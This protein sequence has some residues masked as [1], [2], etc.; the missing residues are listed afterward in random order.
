MEQLSPQS[1]LEYLCH[2]QK[3]HHA[4][5]QSFPLAPTQSH[6]PALVNHESAFC[7]LDLLISEFSHKWNH[8][9]HSLVW[10]GSFTWQ[11]FTRHSPCRS[12]H[13]DVF[14]FYNWVILHCID[15]PNCVYPLISWLMFWTVS[16]FGTLAVTN[17][18]AINIQ[19]QNFCIAIC[20]IFLSY[21]PR[22]A[23]WYDD[24]Y[25]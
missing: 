9:I 18:A 19:V 24:S 6:H 3:K 14:P 4:H 21:I 22:I 2:T 16:T 5:W 10:L 15:I 17:N 20:F 1:I 23:V 25:V 8:N 11:N 7:I 12:M 13:Q